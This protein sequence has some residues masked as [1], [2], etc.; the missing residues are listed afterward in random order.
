MSGLRLWGVAAIGIVWAVGLTFAPTD[1]ASE[2]TTERPEAFDADGRVRTITPSL[3]HRLQLAPPT[4]PVDGAFREARLLR[5]DDAWILAVERSDGTID[6]W[7]LDESER[8]ALG[9]IIGA[10]AASAGIATTD[11]RADVDS[12]PAGGA[13]VRNQM[14][15]ALAIY[16]PTASVALASD[17]GQA[18][19]VYLLTVG[20]TFFA[21]THLSRSRTI[22]SAQAHL[23]TD[24]MWKG[25]ALGSSLVYAST[26]RSADGETYALASLGGSLLGSVAGYQLGK[27]LTDGE[28]H[29]ASFG[30]SVC[31]ALAAGVAGIAGG[32]ESDRSRAEAAW[33][34]AAG[35]LGYPLGATYARRSAYTITAGDIGALTAASGVGVLTASTF[36][37]D[38]G[39]AMTK[40]EAAAVLTGGLLA[41]TLLGDRGL[42][43]RVDHTESEGWLVGI[44]AAAGGLMGAALPLLGEA[45]EPALFVGAA[46]LG[47]ILGLILTERMVA[48]RRAT[49]RTSAPEARR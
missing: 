43:R 1:A 7:T 48:P 23:A 32:Y 17:A 14:T 10:G 2:R 11:E 36:L 20:G 29:G 15:G 33:I 40:R 8:N 5:A 47:S 30:S 21:T 25:A 37:V 31:A 13:F 4:W 49:P 38:R 44:G 35:V 46:S 26:S 42:V 18:T 16:G 9:A 34:S 3:A 24:A 22:S 45:D 41:G 27:S 39:N 6:R 12:R 19:A 28:S